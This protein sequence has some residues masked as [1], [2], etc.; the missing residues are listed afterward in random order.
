MFYSDVI[1]ILVI[2]TDVLRDAIINLNM[3]T[4]N[5][6]GSGSLSKRLMKIHSKLEIK[7]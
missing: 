1:S 7:V 6:G 5:D 2:T 4:I 3:Y